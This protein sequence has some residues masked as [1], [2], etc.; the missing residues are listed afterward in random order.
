[1]HY[2]IDGYN[3]LF[4]TTRASEDLAFQRE[5]IILDLNKKI[6]LLNLDVTIVFDSQYH[7]GESERSHYKLLEIEFTNQGE[8]ADDFIINAVKRAEKPQDHTVI[9][10]DKRL[11]WRVR[12]RAGK[13]ETVEEFQAWINKRYKN[14]LKQITDAQ[15]K[16]ESSIST[17]SK[18][19]IAK[20]VQ[21]DISSSSSPEECFDFYLEE[22][23]KNTDLNASP[24]ISSV[25][26]NTENIKR[27][28]RKLKKVKKE[29]VAL[30]DMERW[31]SIFE[32]KVSESR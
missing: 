23:E 10:S 30:S 12:R 22:F 6:Q 11:A 7:P 9:T 31:L 18:V 20:R 27:F 1:M 13:S 21:K 17:S 19:S 14:R 16:K 24:E 2:F 4:R 28:R 32:K 8:T 5:L 25:Q 15:T 3:L 26:N 29:T